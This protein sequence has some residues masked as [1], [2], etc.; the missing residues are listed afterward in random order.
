[1]NG[2]QWPNSPRYVSEYIV[3]GRKG[4]P[5]FRETKSFRT[6]NYWPRGGHSEKPDGFYDLLRRVTHGPRLDVFGRPPDC[7]LSFLGQ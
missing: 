5:K 6:A 4:S 1:M 7:W 3:V 2:P